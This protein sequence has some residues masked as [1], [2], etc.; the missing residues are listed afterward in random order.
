MS[1]LSLFLLL[2]I[3]GTVAFTIIGFYAKKYEDVA[4]SFDLNE[5]SKMES[6]S[7]LIDRKGREIGKLFIQNRNPV[8]YN[9]I[10][11]NVINAVIAAEDNRF[12]QHSGVDWFG[13]FRA[14]VENYR[15]GRIAQG[16]STVT[17]Q[18]SRNSFDMRERTFERKFI[19]MFLA[20]RV[21]AKFSKQEIMEMYLNR[22]YF[23][24]GFYGV[25]SA[26]RGYFGKSAE[27]L[28]IGESAMLAGLLR[29]PQALSP[30]NNLKAATNIR[31]VVLQQMRDQ[32]FI[33]RPQL[34][35][36]T[37]KPL[38]V[39][40]RTNLHRVSYS[41]DLIRQ[42]AIAA[43]GFEQA[44]NGGYRIFTTLDLDLQKAAEEAMLAQLEKIEATPGY[45]H[46][47]YE[48]YRQR[49]ATLEN[50]VDRGD[51]NARLPAPK[52]LQG[53][54]LS[55]DNTTGGVLTMVGGR[56][57][58]HS[59]YNRAMQ[60][61]RP[62]GTAFTP[63][64]FASAYNNGFSPATVLDDSC[65]DN[66]YVMVGGATGI[67][68]EWGV[69]RTGN[70][71]EGAMTARRALV[72][73]KNAASVRL[74]LLLGTTKLQKTLQSLGIE[75]PL[76]DYANA[77]LG[78]SEMTLEELVLAYT[79]F[80][81]QGSRPKSVFIINQVEDGKGRSIYAAHPE[82]VNAI[83][84]AAATQTH[85]AL[86]EVLTTGTE[87]LAHKRDGLGNFP[88]GGKNGTVYGFTDTYFIGYDSD[89]TTG[90]WVGFDKP[91]RIYHGAFGRDL[92]MPIWSKFMNRVAEVIP[93]KPFKKTLGLEAVEI[94]SVSGLLATPKCQHDA[95]DGRGPLTTTYLEYLTPEQKPKI[96][97]DVHGG[98]L[99]NFAKNYQQE[100]WPRAA[101]TMDLTR[102]RPVAVG[103][104]TLIGFNDIYRAV[105][106]GAI[107][108]AKG[109]VPIAK[110]LPV[111]FAD[112]SHVDAGAL[113]ETSEGVPVAT[114]IPIQGPGEREV[115]KAEIN[116]GYMQ[117]E[118]PSIEL[119]P[120]PPSPF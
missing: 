12:Y 37:N 72:G 66:R 116:A 2:L 67:L 47:K 20:R 75:S 71:Y 18:L 64:L 70:E 98:G 44:M 96:I 30:W 6:A 87:N 19:E 43:L 49:Y 5:V 62:S 88:V 26:A 91:T 78:S 28:G 103:D 100:E 107:R 59:E 51:P 105:Q 83:S 76:R 29:S 7:L 39:L 102:I 86:E 13:I 15:K 81:N 34:L 114:A 109:E 108:F 73:G 118:R 40:H 110:A 61:K 11:Q 48:N 97:C 82:I 117:L 89:V 45:E 111:E 14:M 69:E 1:L 65:I 21:E 4:D 113:G 57:F 50:Q 23:G 119:A 22:V 55:L 52:Y 95:H 60:S 104:K 36:E 3:G 77:Y 106:P 33:T 101:A 24:S 53:A 79:V 31:D 99:R 54:L 42:Q 32:G 94:C 80:P 68:G 90:V 38:F 120:P 112:G 85:L 16:A 93:P 46:E 17:Q 84:P 115:R 92:A 25:E 8:P 63:L 9:K 35:E 58:R 10:S 74:G 41:I 27:N 56:D